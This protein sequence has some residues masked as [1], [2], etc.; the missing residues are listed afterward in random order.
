VGSQ[1]S[2]DLFL[3]PTGQNVFTVLRNWSLQR[4]TRPRFQFVIDGLREAFPGFE[5]LDVEQAG[6]TVTVAVHRAGGRKLPI[7]QE[8]TGFLGAMLHLTAIASAGPGSVVA[9]D[10]IE[11]SLHP[12]IIRCLLRCAGR[13][14]ARHRLCVL[15]ATHSP[16]V[17]DQFKEEPEHVFVMEPGREEQPARLDELHDPEWLAH[18]SL[19]DLYAHDEFGAQRPGC[20]SPAMA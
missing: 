5:E 19:G 7:A 6:T 20:G 1:H 13:W 14:A 8:S 12:E 9:I 18:F 15:L 2:S 3:D 11:D 17:L 10:Q 4:E 16:V